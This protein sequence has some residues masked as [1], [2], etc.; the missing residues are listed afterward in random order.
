MTLFHDAKISSITCVDMQ[1]RTR[2]PYFH[3]GWALYH[4]LSLDYGEE[5]G[6]QHAHYSSKRFSCLYFNRAPLFHRV[7]VE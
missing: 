4:L 3:P 2:I 5:F 7:V 1:H 6:K